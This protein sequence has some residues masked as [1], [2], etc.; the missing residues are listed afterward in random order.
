MKKT[1]LFSFLFLLSGLFA[2]N[3]LAQDMDKYGGTLKIA[4]NKKVSIFGWPPEVRASSGR[5]AKMSLQGLIEA[6]KG[7]NPGP[8]LAT[9][10]EL[11]S[12]DSKYTFKLRKGIKFHD[13]SDFN[14][15]A[16]KWNLDNILKG[17]SPILSGVKS[18]D[19][20]DDHTVQLNL[21]KWTNLILHDLTGA[22]CYM[23]S[24]TAFEKHDKKWTETNPIGTGPFKFTEFKRDVHVKYEKFDGYWEKGLPYLDAVEWHIIINP[25]TAYATLKA[26]EVHVMYDLDMVSGRDLK[27]EE[28][29]IVRWIPG[30]NSLIAVNTKDPNSI[31]ADK[32]L[33]EA[34]E[35]AIDKE[36][37][38][39]NL[40]YGFMEPLYQ[41]INRGP[42]VPDE[43]KRTYNPEK[44]KQL[45][46]E[47]GYPNGFKTAIIMLEF[48]PRDTMGALQNQ[49]AKLGIELDMQYL[50]PPAYRQLSLEGGIG[51]R[52][53]VGVVPG[54]VFPLFQANSHLSSKSPNRADTRRT[55]GWDDLIDQAMQQ[56]DMGKVNSILQKMERL[57][58]D[59]VMLIPL[60]P[61][62]MILSYHTSVK[63]AEWYLH[64]T[65]DYD[66]K[67]AWL[68]KK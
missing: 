23:I 63:D 19:A 62:P 47:A 2:F 10:W 26:K 8:L 37:I 9:T 20:I 13:G 50:A 52:M 42:G 28:D 49:L 32:K 30:V 55:P 22:S 53:I 15:Q 61:E 17:R 40:G 11:A 39:K 60:W 4:T 45:M 44:A 3:G 31:F 59:D 35:Y 41:I 68:S 58:Y 21:E 51:D 46:A 57:A 33:R 38:C 27:K 24:P 67:R 34:V 5:Y 1:L 12:D 36:T 29:Y 6:G 64:G 14:A 48:L 66:L 7:G 25:M 16:V 54:G 43:M 56:K 18:V 65:P